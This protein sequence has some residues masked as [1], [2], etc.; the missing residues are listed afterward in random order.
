VS[1][2]PVSL[3]SF[4]AVSLAAALVFGAGTTNE[5]VPNVLTKPPGY[6]LTWEYT[7]CDTEIVELDEVWWVICVFRMGW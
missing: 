6:P 2:Q 3:N 1:R 5:L 4:A 7:G